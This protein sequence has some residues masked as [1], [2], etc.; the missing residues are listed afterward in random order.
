M[1][2]KNGKSQ[3]GGGKF[4]KKAIGSYGKDKYL[5][6]KSFEELC[7][8]T[9]MYN[10][11]LELLVLIRQKYMIHRSKTNQIDMYNYT[12]IYRE[13]V[14]PLASETEIYK[15]FNS[16]DKNKK[17]YLTLEVITKL[18]IFFYNN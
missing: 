13:L 11:P 1:G 12:V 16:F 7:K 5:G 3:S 18:K 10:V 8:L 2:N 15:S 17:R 14:N 9:K 6:K 4:G